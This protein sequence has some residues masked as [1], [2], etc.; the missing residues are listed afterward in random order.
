MMPTPTM[1]NMVV[2]L[3]ATPVI[4]RARGW[5]EGLV[6]EAQEGMAPSAVCALNHRHGMF[7]LLH[8]V[9]ALTLCIQVVQ[10][11]EQDASIVRKAQAPWE[12]SA[13]YP[14]G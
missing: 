10:S 7:R 5:Q 1:V 8:A 4:P 2:G 14:Q 9:T 11:M 12:V 13:T 6:K 3:A